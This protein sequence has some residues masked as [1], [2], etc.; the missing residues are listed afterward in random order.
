MHDH[1]HFKLA[2]VEKL[3]D[4]EAEITGEITLEFLNECKKDALKH[5]NEHVE[6]PGFRKGNIPEDILTK[7][8]GVMGVLEEAAE[9]ALGR[10]YSHIIEESKLRPL[11]RPRISVTK[12]APNIPLEFK[13]NVVLEPEFELPDYKKIAGEIKEE[14]KEKRRALIL[15]ALGKETKLEVPKKFIDGEVEHMVHHFKHDI[16]KAQIDWNKYLEQIKKTEDEIKNEWRE[17]V[18]SR[19]KSELILTKIAEKENLKT[20]REVFDLLEK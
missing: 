13:I 1:T 16:E 14:N 4:W 6:L 10:E 12:L 8:V 15:E 18:I 11:T 19:A 2:K 5:L 9:I 7:H 3:P 20:Y 17:S